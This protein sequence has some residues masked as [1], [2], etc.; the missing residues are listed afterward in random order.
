MT[1]C[2]L[3]SGNNK[4]MPCAYS[5]EVTGCLRYQELLNKIHEA[6]EIYTGADAFIARTAPEAYQ[7]RLLRQMYEAL[8]ND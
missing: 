5:T 6:K 2:E 3:C 4:D 8:T 7:Q 1:E